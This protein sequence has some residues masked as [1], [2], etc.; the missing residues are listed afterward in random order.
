M[1]ADDILMLLSSPVTSL[2]SLHVVLRHFS[3]FTGLKVNHSKSQ[4]LSVSLETHIVQAL[5]KSFPF[6]WQN[7]TLPYLG[8]FL[9]PTLT[10]LYKH[11]YL[12]LF[13]KLLEDLKRWSGNPPLWFGRL[14]SVKMIVLPK[15][16]YLFRTLLIAIVGKDLQKFRT[17]LLDYIWGH[18]RPRVNSRTLYPSKLRG[19]LGMLDLLKYFQAAQIAQLFRFHTQQPR[20]LWMSLESSLHPDREISHLMWM[21]GKDR[22]TIL[23]PNL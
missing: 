1:F 20:L 18:K 23:C 8:I 3:A 4:A 12:P 2:P 15:V 16:L 6:K 11:N 13:R 22:P 17:K 5:Q 10:T 14:C 7:E 9:T 19:G 21:K